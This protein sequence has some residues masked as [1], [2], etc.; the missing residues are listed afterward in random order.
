MD[1]E[2]HAKNEW[3]KQVKRDRSKITR[4]HLVGWVGQMDRQLCQ[5]GLAAL[6]EHHVALAASSLQWGNGRRHLVG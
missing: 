2:R 3:V 4:T 6:N 1:E 5:A